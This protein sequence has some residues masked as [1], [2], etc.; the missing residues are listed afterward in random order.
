[1]YCTW[2]F[3]RRDLCRRCLLRARRT[4]N[5]L[6][7]GSRR[8]DV[9]LE[10]HCTCY[11]QHLQFFIEATF[12]TWSCWSPLPGDCT[13]TEQVWLPILLPEQ[14][15]KCL[16]RASFIERHRYCSGGKSPFTSLIRFCFLNLATEPNSIQIT[17][18]MYMYHRENKDVV[19]LLMIQ[20]KYRI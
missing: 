14:G 1:M 2:Y 18:N 5:Q 13:S 11:V 4:Q 15:N 3:I 16:F 10:Y 12:L 19:Q 9:L 6:Y 17:K 7:V 20:F 8:A